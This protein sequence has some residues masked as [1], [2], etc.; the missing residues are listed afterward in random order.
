MNTPERQFGNAAQ[1]FAGRLEFHRHFWTSFTTEVLMKIDVPEA[2]RI[3]NYVADAV[4]AMSIEENGYQS[5]FQ[6]GF[7]AE[8]KRLLYR[9]SRDVS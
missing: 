1:E 9:L 3:R 5:A 8:A 2:E 6:Q 4:R 7:A